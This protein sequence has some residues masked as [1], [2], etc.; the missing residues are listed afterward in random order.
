MQVD[1][2]EE[3][4]Q[5]GVEVF[6]NKSEVWSMNWLKEKQSFLRKDLKFDCIAVMLS[7]P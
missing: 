5:G 1:I 6:V 2:Q 4:I 7:V 3:I